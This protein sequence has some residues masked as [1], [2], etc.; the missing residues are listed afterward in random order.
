MIFNKK[1]QNSSQKAQ[2]GRE[3]GVH[4]LIGG[5][6]EKFRAC[7]CRVTVLCELRHCCRQV[8]NILLV[9]CF[10]DP[11]GFCTLSD[12]GIHYPLEQQAL[13]GYECTEAYSLPR[14]LYV[15]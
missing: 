9:C 3:K 4:R 11:P 12:V 13:S 15:K 10:L 8:W 14:G 6:N 2:R 5:G 1:L 7:N